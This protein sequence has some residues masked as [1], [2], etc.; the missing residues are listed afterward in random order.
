MQSNNPVFRNSDEFNGKATNAY[1][2]QVYGGAGT[3]YRRLRPADL[4]PLHLEHRHAGSH[5]A[6]P[7]R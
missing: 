1:G 2:N 3:A 4:R 7:G 5:P 6:P